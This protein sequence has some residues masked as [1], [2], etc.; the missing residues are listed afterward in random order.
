MFMS[1]ASASTVGAR[2]TAATRVA[3][4]GAGSCAARRSTRCRS[5]CSSSWKAGKAGPLLG[6]VLGV[7]PQCGF[8]AVAATLWSGRLVT[9]GTLI[10]VFLSTSDELLPVFVAEGAPLDLLVRILLTKMAIGIAVG[11]AV[12]AVLRLVHRDG[13]GHMHVHELCEREH[14][15]CEGH[16]CHEG[17]GTWGGVVRSAT[18]HTL[19]VTLFIFLVTLVVG[20]AIELVGEDAFGSFM[21]GNPVLSVFSAALVGLIPNCAAS[22]VVTELFLDGTLGSAALLA[23]TLVAAG[24]GYLVLFRTNA[25][26]RQNLALIAFLYA[27][28]VASGLVMLAFGWSF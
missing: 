20:T 14:C 27:V 9:V 2:G 23:G 10:A 22:V 6:G 24:V 28:G 15:G 5:R 3:E 13:D 16:G 25:N 19:Q 1:C 17:G 18:K 21:A 26:A 7:V 11:L 8:S 12:D 4:P